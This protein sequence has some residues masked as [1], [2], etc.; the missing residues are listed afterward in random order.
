MSYPKQV[1]NNRWVIQVQ[2]DSKTKELYLQFPQ[3]ALDQVGWDIGDSLIWEELD[4]N[5]WSIR[6]KDEDAEI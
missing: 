1:G 4:H 3:D 2:E 6:K 5:K